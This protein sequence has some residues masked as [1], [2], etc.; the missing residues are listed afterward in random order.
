[1]VRSSLLLSALLLAS[2]ASMESGRVLDPTA[3]ESLELG[4]AT[5]AQ[6]EAVL[7]PPAR[8]VENADGSTVISYAHLTSRA[9]A[10]GGAQARAR[11]AAFLFDADGVLQR[12]ST[13]DSDAGSDR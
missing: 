8:V 1:M 7:G 5:R 12:K 10:F 4:S 9:T 3:I 2:C 11:T 6:V 13:G